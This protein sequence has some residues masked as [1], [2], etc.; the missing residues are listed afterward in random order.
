ME[1]EI[2]LIGKDGKVI[3]LTVTVTTPG[4]A[5]TEVKLFL[6]DGTIINKGNSTNGAGLISDRPMDVDTKL[7]N[8]TIKIETIILLSKVPESAWENCFDNLEINYYLDG[9][10]E[11][12]NI[13]FKLHNNEKRKSS[14]GELI[15]AIK[16]IDL[17]RM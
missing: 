4:I 2:Y 10:A 6:S 15:R 7:D 13:P 1:N 17:N 16:R 5:T 9:G 14:N 3:T 8:S 11:N 12:Q